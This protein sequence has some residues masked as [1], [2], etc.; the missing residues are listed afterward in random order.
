[1][2]S[3]SRFR[4]DPLSIQHLSNVN[5]FAM[6]NQKFDMLGLLRSMA[7]NSGTFC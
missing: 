2:I 4:K 7:V 3:E 5:I 6:T 1:M